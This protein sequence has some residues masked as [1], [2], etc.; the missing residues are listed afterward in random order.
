MVESSPQ[1]RLSTVHA[2][3]SAWYRD[4]VTAVYKGWSRPIST[5]LRAATGDCDPVYG[6]CRCGLLYYSI[7]SQAVTVDFCNGHRV[8]GS[9]AARSQAVFG[10]SQA[11]TPVTALLKYN[12]YWCDHP[13]WLVGITM[14]IL[15]R[16][17]VY[18]CTE[19]ACA[20]NTGWP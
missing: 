3:E 17:E 13:L 4:S 9:L 15:V 10:W 12:A 11:V 20:F 18:T 16:Q 2:W 14:W 8:T 6:G 7:K 5:V 19:H 1:T